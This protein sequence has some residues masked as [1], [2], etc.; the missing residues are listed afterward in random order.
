MYITV[1]HRCVGFCVLVSSLAFQAGKGRPQ[2]HTRRYGTGHRLPE[3]LEVL[4]EQGGG[5][6][7]RLREGEDVPGSFG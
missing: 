3:D 6:R 5:G 2:S 4:L 1:Y 7:T